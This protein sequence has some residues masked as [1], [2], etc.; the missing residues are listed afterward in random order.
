MLD[1][2]EFFLSIVGKHILD[3]DIAETLKV[4]DIDNNAI[5][6]ISKDVAK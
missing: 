6:I 3:F 5:G 2:L 4:Y 1:D